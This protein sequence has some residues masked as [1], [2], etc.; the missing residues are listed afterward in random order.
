MT[1][2]DATALAVSDADS[3]AARVSSNYPLVGWE[4]DSGQAR[5]KALACSMILSGDEGTR[6]SD[7][8]DRT[9]QP[10]RQA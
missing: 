3:K 9:W 10:V 5:A 8:R 2:A 1:P 7:Q 4:R 6:R